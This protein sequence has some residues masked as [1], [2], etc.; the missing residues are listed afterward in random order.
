MTM[1]GI[2]VFAGTTAMSA[3]AAALAPAGG[4]GEAAAESGAVADAAAAG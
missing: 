1:S 2:T 4:V 3:G